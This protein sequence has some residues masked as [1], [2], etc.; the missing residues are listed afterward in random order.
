MRTRIT[1]NTDTLDRVIPFELL[2]RKALN[3]KMISLKLVRLLELRM[4][5]SR[6]FHSITVE[7]KKQFVK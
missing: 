6:L 7:G 3:F 1:P 2:Q 4:F 5:K